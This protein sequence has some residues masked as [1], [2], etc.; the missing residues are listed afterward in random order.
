MRKVPECRRK[1]SLE[2]WRMAN[3]KWKKELGKS[4]NDIVV[5]QKTA[6]E[7]AGTWAE[8]QAA[9][10][11]CCISWSITSWQA[12]WPGYVGVNGG[13]NTVDMMDKYLGLEGRIGNIGRT[14]SFEVKE[15]L[16]CRVDLYFCTY[17]RSYT[18]IRVYFGSCLERPSRE[19]VHWLGTVV[20]LSVVNTMSVPIVDDLDRGFI[21]KV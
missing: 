15:K 18:G 1:G 10:T 13:N 14:W 3:G 4:E 5:K 8:T 2:E 12:G 19:K 9:G 7:Q 21:Y 6:E 11:R 20:L 16:Y 17:S